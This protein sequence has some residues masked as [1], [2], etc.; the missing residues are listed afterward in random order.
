[1]NWE[2][3]NKLTDKELFALPHEEFLKHLI[4]FTEERYI[5]YKKML[6]DLFKNKDIFPPG[7]EFTEWY[8]ELLR[9]GKN[10]EEGDLKE[11][12]LEMEYH[13]QGLNPPFCYPEYKRKNPN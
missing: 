11:L 6:E 9:E 1:M 12:R 5:S 8:K 2:E 4:K 13:R 10:R 7:D 3:W